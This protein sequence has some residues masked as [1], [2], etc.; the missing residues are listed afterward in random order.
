RAPETPRARGGRAASQAEPEIDGVR[1]P[2]DLPD[3]KL[4]QLLR[5][6]FLRELLRTAL[7][8][9]V[10]LLGAR[11]EAALGNVADAAHA[12]RERRAKVGGRSEGGNFADGDMDVVARGD[13]FG[14]TGGDLL[15][16]VL[17]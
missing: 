5:F 15:D 13:V 6:H 14:P 7:Q 12:L 9:H 8:R 17:A 16:H 3:G 11:R 2:S 1:G 10:Q 4:P